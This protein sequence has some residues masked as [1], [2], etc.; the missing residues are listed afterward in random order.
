M[1]KETIRC[2][3][4]YGAF[5]IDAETGDVLTK[6]PSEYADHAKGNVVECREWHSKI[7]LRIA[8]EMDVVAIGWW[9]KDGSYLPPSPEF[10]EN[11]ENFCK[12]IIR[13]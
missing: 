12:D 3:G 1:P 10:R 5:R 11:V 8:G 7:G 9:L 4:S 6:L 2:Y 13:A